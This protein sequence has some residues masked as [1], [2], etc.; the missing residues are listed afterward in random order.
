MLTTFIGLQLDQ[1]MP[2]AA[3]MSFELYIDTSDVHAVNGS[4]L[5]VQVKYQG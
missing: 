1:Y 3:M 5:Y 2:D 4:N